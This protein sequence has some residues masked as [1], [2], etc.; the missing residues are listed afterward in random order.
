MLITAT[1]MLL[2]EQKLHVADGDA[3][4]TAKSSYSWLLLPACS[5]KGKV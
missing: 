2:S 5:G 3:V 1:S 4:Q